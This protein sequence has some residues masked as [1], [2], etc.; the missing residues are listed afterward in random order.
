MM[1][2]GGGGEVLCWTPGTAATAE[3]GGPVGALNDGGGK[4]G[5]ALGGALG[6]MV[7][8]AL[9]GAR[10]GAVAGVL[11]V[12]CVGPALGEFPGISI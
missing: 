10:G 7:G 5:G 4:L 3:V 6:G 9:G 12:S 2:P 11:E 8:G 1:M